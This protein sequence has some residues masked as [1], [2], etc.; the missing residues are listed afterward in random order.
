MQAGCRPPKT[1]TPLQ[2]ILA[3]ELYRFSSASTIRLKVQPLEPRI[4]IYQTDVQLGAEF[5]GG[6]GLA[7]DDG[8]DPG[9]C[10]TD[11]AL[12]NAVGPGLEHEPLLFVD[13]GDHV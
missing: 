5:R 11:D 1:T 10:Q 8:T 6:M 9:L 13:C 3:A 2:R 12:G 7:P 4:A